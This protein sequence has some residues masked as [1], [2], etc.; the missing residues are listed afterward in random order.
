M[1][2]DTDAVTE[3]LESIEDQ[4]ARDVL[5]EAILELRKVQRRAELDSRI[6][7]KFLNQLPFLRDGG[8]YSGGSELYSSGQELRVALDPT[9]KTKP[10]VW[11]EILGVKIADPDGWDRSAPDFQAEW[12]TPLTRDE[13]MY[14]MMRSTIMGYSFGSVLDGLK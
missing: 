10:V 9:V 12:N 14:R 6:I 4:K 7:Q 13:F 3:A 11:E 1:T 2:F 5:R 8:W